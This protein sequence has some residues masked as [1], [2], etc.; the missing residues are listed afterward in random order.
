VIP[1]LHTRGIAFRLILYIITS[2]TLIFTIT[3]GYNYLF[4][5]RIITNKIEENARNLALRTV[6]RIETVL[7][8]VEKVPQNIAY[9]LETSSY[10]REGI[11]NLLRTVV[12][13]NS[14]IYGSTI[15]YEPYAFDK[16]SRLFGP[17]Y[18]KPGGKL[19]F[20]CLDGNYNYIVWDWYTMPKK[21]AA[22][23][24]TEPYF[25][26]GGGNII[27]SPYCVPF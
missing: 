1:M 25:D 11:L 26:K 6:N 20:T 22:P 9:S 14:E 3:F 27:M 15:S 17:Y 2:C 12:E 4:S 5:R 23:V 21:L 18:Y 19:S 16:K 8:S 13:N 10:T 7:R 24:W